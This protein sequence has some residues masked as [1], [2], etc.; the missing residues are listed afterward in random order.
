MLFLTCGLRL[1]REEQPCLPIQLMAPFWSAWERK[2]P[3]ERVTAQGLLVKLHLCETTSD[4]RNSSGTKFQDTCLG[5]ESNKS[6]SG[7]KFVP[8]QPS[9]LRSRGAEGTCHAQCRTQVSHSGVTWSGANEGGAVGVVSF[10]IMQ[11]SWGRVFSE[12]LH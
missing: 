4:Y 7:F 8:W 11:K 9:P 6:F 10:K 2:T 1:F 3:R 12:D 5:L